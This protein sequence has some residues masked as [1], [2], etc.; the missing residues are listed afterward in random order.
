MPLVKYNALHNKIVFFI[1]KSIFWESFYGL[2]YNK[3]I[4]NED[5]HISLKLLKI[6]LKS[7]HGS[8]C[9]W[10]RWVAEIKDLNF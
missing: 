1:W 3:H 2:Y 4:N 6:L 7:I 8:A 9:E 5:N 10:F